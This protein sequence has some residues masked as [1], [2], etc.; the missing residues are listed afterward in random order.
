MYAQPKVANLDVD[1]EQLA[2]AQQELAKCQALLDEQAAAVEQARVS[3]VG[4][5]AMGDLASIYLDQQN[6]ELLQLQALERELAPRMAM[7]KAIIQ[8]SQA[9]QTVMAKASKPL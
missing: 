8:G 5:G 6:T 4:A 3:A 7:A 1:Q 9:A 2:V